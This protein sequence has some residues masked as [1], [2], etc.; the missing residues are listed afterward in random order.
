V[1]LPDD[2]IAKRANAECGNSLKVVGA[3]I[4]ASEG[5]LIEVFVADAVDG[6]FQSTPKLQRCS[7]GHG[8]RPLRS[9]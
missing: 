2:G 3:F 9:Q 7:F 4:M 8:V 1:A 6:A 5:E